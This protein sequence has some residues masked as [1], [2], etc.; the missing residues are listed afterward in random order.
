MTIA[1]IATLADRYTIEREIGHGGMATVY[2]AEDRKH[3]RKVALKIMRADVASSLGAERFLREVRLAAQLSHP[4]IVPLIDSGESDGVLFYVT[5]YAP[6][7]SL[8]DRITREG[9]LPVSDALR[10]AREVGLGL[11]YVHR[12]G[13]VHRDVKPANILFADGHAVL[14]D[15]GI[16]YAACDHER[17]AITGA[18]VVIGTPEY[19]SPEQASGERDLEGQSDIYSLACVVYEMLAGA[20]PFDGSN[21]RV[22]M[23]RQVTET[24][25]PLRAARP[26]A[27]ATLERA[28]VRALA[29][30]PR[31]RPPTVPAFLDALETEGLEGEHYFASRTHA[32]AVLPFV[33]VSPD[34]ENEYLSD[35]ITD[36]L[37]GA[38]ARVEGLQV[39]SRTSVFSLKGKPQDV[40]AIGSLL[41]VS[42]VLEGT[43]RR[44]GDRL[45][46]GVQLTS[47]QDGRL[48]WSQRYDRELVDVFSLQDDIARTIVD[49]L[50]TGSFADLPDPK[51]NRYTTNLRAYGYY[52]KGRYAWNKR[53]Q[54]GAR[55]A[56]DFFERA[57]AEDPE[58]AVA[59]AGLS[60]S[61]ALHVDY[62]DVPVHEGLERAKEYA[63]KAIELDDGVAEAHASLAWCLFIYDWDWAASDRESRRAIELDPRYAAAHQWY[64]F[65][66][67][68]QGRGEDSVAS[69]QRAIELDP[70]S[71][72][73]RRSIA[74]ANYYA[75][76]YDQALYHSQRA[77]VMNP[78]AEESYRILGLTLAQSGQLDEAERVMREAVELPG[79][80]IYAKGVLGFVL[81]RSGQLA[82]ARQLL[83]ELVARAERGYVS[84]VV[85]ALLHIGLDERD[86]ALDWVERAH[87]ERRGWLAYLRV[88]ALF[89]P[90]RGAPRFEAL[91]RRM[92]L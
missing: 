49:T 88:N 84:P 18:G 13:Y 67:A 68:S 27:P 38:L 9:R 81:A 79:G 87:E 58:Y 23:V 66:L 56:I 62:R 28:L 53:T 29:K 71:V 19:M 59:Y 33:N 17:E 64:T 44:A 5:P 72:S 86:R 4:H 73:G 21:A 34:P 42:E 43:V 10:V 31:E 74:W 35:G 82:K 3:G 69:A 50:R 12:S 39:A 92:K 63:R 11:D 65:L 20:P 25:A 83:D 52:L 45:R 91:A 8:A 47:T 2:L 16:A 22:T 90:L 60:D 37:I 41:G 70:A 75:R 36:E 30:D 40:R 26:E 85:F 89:D 78:T 76:R 32:I 77:I 57:I 54:D 7:G 6:G 55:E 61:Y 24:P 80:S 51:P 46:I 15:F 1:V 48:L 14:A